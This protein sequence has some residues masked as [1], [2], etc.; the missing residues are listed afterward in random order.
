[1][2]RLQPR[3]SS[4]G[5]HRA[6]AVAT[7]ALGAVK[8]LVGAA[9]GVVRAGDAV[10]VEGVHADADGDLDVVFAG[11]DRIGGDTGTHRLG[12]GYRLRSVQ[13]WQG[14]NEFLAAEA[15]EHAAMLGEDIAHASRRGAQAF[16]ADQVAVGVV[17]SFEVVEIDHQH[18]QV[19]QILAGVVE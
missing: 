1:A 18:R 17:D 5:D 8:R 16:V 7:A 19:L 10:G 9:Q 12:D 15:G 13:A 2:L 4:L 6:Y 3:V 11:A 14:G